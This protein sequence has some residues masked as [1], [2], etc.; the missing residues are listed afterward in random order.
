MTY[1]GL[2]ATAMLLGVFVAAGGAYGI[3]Y[4]A[5]RLRSSA[6]LA[7]AGQACYALQLLIALVVCLGSPLA[8]PW[9]VFIAA[10]AVAY[11]FIPPLIWRLLEIMHR[12]AGK[13]PRLS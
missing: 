6:V 1:A 11:G 8:L 13:E 12:D 7:R 2:F 4:A 3:L 9:K 10:S 5:A